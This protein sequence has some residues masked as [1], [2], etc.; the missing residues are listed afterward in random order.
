MVAM[1]TIVMNHVMDVYLIPVIKNM[2]SVQ[3]H[4]DVN[5]DGNTGRRSVIYVCS[6]NDLLLHQNNKQKQMNA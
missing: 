5:L 4:L 6:R 2:V 3:I 1:V